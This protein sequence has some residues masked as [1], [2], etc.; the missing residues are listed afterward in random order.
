[1][2]FLKVFSK[3]T[4]QLFSM[5]FLK[6]FSNGL[7]LFE[8]EAYNCCTLIGWFSLHADWP[9]YPPRTFRFLMYGHLV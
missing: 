6:V 7:S 3:W 9:E 8:K 1:M 5:A 4:G 2:A